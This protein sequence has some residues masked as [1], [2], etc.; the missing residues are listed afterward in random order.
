MK[1]SIVL[2]I[3][4]VILLTG[5]VKSQY[6]WGYYSYTLYKYKKA[7]TDETLEKH[8]MSME[9]IIRKSEDKEKR[10]PP[11]IYCEY[12]YYLIQEGDVAQGMEYF[13]K[14]VKAYPESETFINT[15]KSQLK[16]E[17]EQS[18]E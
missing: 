7:Q 6:Y 10:V 14:E 18:D 4:S 13:D 8:K 12:G 15:L 17:K 3:L 16:L 5:C 2:L 11:G 1:K 9:K